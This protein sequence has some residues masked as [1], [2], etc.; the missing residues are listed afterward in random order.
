MAIIKEYREF[1]LRHLPV[2][3]GTKPDQE[4]NFPSQYYIGST[5]VY[6]RFLKN[7]FPSEKVFRKLFESLPFKLNKEDTA[8]LT[9]QGLTKIASDA[10]AETRTSNAANDFTALVAPHQL[11]DVVVNDVVGDTASIATK[12][13]ISV[14]TIRRT[15]GS[16]FRRIFKI[17]LVGDVDN[18]GTDKFY[19]TDDTG[20]RTWRDPFYTKAKQSVELDNDNK[21]HLVNDEDNPGNSEYYGTDNVGARGYHALPVP[22]TL[23]TTGFIVMYHGVSAPGGW[24]ICDGQNGT[25]DLRGRFVVAT[26]QNVTP[27]GGETTNPT[28]ILDDKGGEN[29]HQLTYNELPKHS[30]EYNTYNDSS[31]NSGLTGFANGAT[32]KSKN[33]VYS[34]DVSPVESTY[35]RHENRPPYYALMFIMKL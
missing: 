12:A 24:A 1:F 28:Y 35:S 2:S 5:R 34:S 18:P 15:F 6:N 19:G 26:G 13:S 25:P 30:H 9:E 10:N 11:P 27:A 21:L 31:G 22:G 29:T 16:T 3:S 4:A 32:A 33:N 14:T 20:T 17:T 8:K 23:L 7:D